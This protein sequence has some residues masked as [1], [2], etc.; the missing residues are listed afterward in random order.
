MNYD[1]K[2][3]MINPAAL[4]KCLFS[5]FKAIVYERFIVR[6]DLV[7][8]ISNIS[9]ALTATASPCT[10]DSMLKVVS[11][12]IPLIHA[13]WH[14]DVPSRKTFNRCDHMLALQHQDGTTTVVYMTDVIGNVA[15]SAFLTGSVSIRMSHTTCDVM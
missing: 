11:S 14:D 1:D 12:Q 8:F 3:V 15:L 4:L 7:C 13:C 2:F 10:A 5:A 9:S 6:L